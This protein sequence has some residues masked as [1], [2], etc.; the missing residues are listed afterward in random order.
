MFFKDK[1]ILII[2]GTGTLGQSLVKKILKENPKVIRIFSRDEYKQFLF[3]NEVGE[4]KK[5]R[6]LI[7]DVRNYD[8]VLNAMAG[9]DY[10]FHTAAMKHVPSCEYNPYEAVLT[11]IIGTNNVINAAIRQNVKKVVFTSSDKAISP[12]N[13]YGATKLTAERLITSAEYSKGAS[14]TVFSSVRFGNVIGSR[15]SVIPLF[16]NQ[17]LTQKR[18]TITDLSMSRFMMTLTQATELTI[19]ALQESK[20]GETFV[21]KMP[22]IILND[23]L[24]VILDEM[25]K[26]HNLIQEEIIIQEI[27]LRP[28][29]KMYEELMTSDESTFA[30]E[31]PEMFLIPSA[32]GQKYQYPNAKKAKK[33]TYGSDNQKPISKEEVRALLQSEGLI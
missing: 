18:V 21:L 29:E 15:G 3:Q 7:G 22:V 4:Q 27:G 16:K 1:K 17:I 20:G 2:G 26:K 8:R 28:G 11:N 5:L 14:N 31:M 9:I 33:G 10:V 30:W 12:T 23:L 32:Y 13:N 25:C 6:F 24:E 19:K